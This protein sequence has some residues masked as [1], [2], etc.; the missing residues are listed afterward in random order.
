MLRK[1]KQTPQEQS[2]Q[3]FNLALEVPAEQ[4]PKGWRPFV[5]RNWKRIAAAA[6]AAPAHAEHVQ[7]AV[8]LAK[9]GE[10]QRTAAF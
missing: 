2:D 5:R 9:V 4:R 10:L 6:C 3:E 1:N 7:L 8:P